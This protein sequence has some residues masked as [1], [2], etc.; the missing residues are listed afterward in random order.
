MDS[1]KRTSSSLPPLRHIFPSLAPSLDISLRKPHILPSSIYHNLDSEKHEIRILTILPR[2]R[3]PVTG[4][5]NPPLTGGVAMRTS[6]TDIHCILETKPLDDKPSYKALSYVWGAET[7]ST[8][9]IVNSQVISVRQNLGAALQHVRQEDHSM[10]VWADA[11]CINQHDNQEKL[12]QVQLMSK[13]YLSS[14]EVLV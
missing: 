14:A 7:P 6:A 5:S 12:H 4:S 2:G 9:I 1:P 13:I 10:S 3:E 8:T 11:L